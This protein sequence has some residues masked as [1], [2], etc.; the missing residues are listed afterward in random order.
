MVTRIVRRALL[1]GL[2]VVSPHWRARLELFHEPFRSRTPWHSGLAEAGRVLYSV[3]RM[4]QPKVIVE[5]GSARGYSTCCI[6]LACAENFR[7]H[8]HAIDPHTANVWTDKGT[9]ALTRDFLED[10]LR[11][12]DLKQYCT[13]IAKP[14]IDAAAEWSTPIDLLF[15]DGDHTLAGVTNDF[16]LFGKWMAPDGLVAFHDTAWEHNQP[17]TTFAT[18]S[19]YRGDDMGVAEY[20]TQLQRE[21]YQGVT[22]LPIPGLTLMQPGPGGF[23]YTRRAKASEL[24]LA[25]RS[26]GK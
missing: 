17:W 25:M 11:R 1:E 13:V 10:R 23:E 21:G 4:A 6:A 3:V 19:W 2:R 7:G 5:I 24:P 26:P 14:S 15:I 8:V 12:Y 9:G 22:L 20:M 16:T 18:E